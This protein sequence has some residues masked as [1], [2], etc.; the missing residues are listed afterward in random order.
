M[1]IKFEGGKELEA[2]LNEL[3]QATSSRAGKNAIKRGLVRGGEPIAERARELVPVLS[4]RLRDSIKVSSRTVNKVGKAEFAAAMRSGAGIDAAVSALRDARRA[5]AGSGSNVEVYVGP[6]KLPH[7]HLV[8]FGSVNNEPPQP[9]MRPA[10][11][12]R[13]EKALGV[14]RD[15]VADEIAKGTARARRKA[16]KA[17]G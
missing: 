9:Y 6:G 5:A 15:A 17:K 11:E 16:R 12:E 10:F 2:A 1:K 4:G 14:I 8:E 3:I 13:K 7:A